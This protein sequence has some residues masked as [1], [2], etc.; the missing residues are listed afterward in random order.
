MT[1]YVY[2]LS[3]TE[4]FFTVPIKHRTILFTTDDKV[5]NFDGVSGA[6]VLQEAIYFI[7]FEYVF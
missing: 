6:N 3:N 5:L 1:V 7:V 2:Y 4:A